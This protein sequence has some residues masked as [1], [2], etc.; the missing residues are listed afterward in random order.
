MVSCRGVPSVRF[1]SAFKSGFLYGLYVLVGTSILVVGHLSCWNPNFP[2]ASGF[3]FMRAW[4]MAF[5]RHKDKQA[6]MKQPCL[7]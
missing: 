5:S 1:A 6:C 2:E 4:S 3:R 7:I